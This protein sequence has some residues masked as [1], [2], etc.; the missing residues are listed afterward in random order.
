MAIA[1]GG[2]LSI[3]RMDGTSGSLIYQHDVGYR[4]ID[5]ARKSK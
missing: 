3:I 5:G 2:Y 4:D 1:I